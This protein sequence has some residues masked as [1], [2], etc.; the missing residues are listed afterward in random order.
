MSLCSP[1]AAPLQPGRGY[2]LPP[3]AYYR[4]DWFL[5]EQRQLFGRT[6]NFVGET[7]DLRAPGDFLTADVGGG[8]IVV[9]RDDD[10]MLRA[11]HNV[12]RHRGAKLLDARGN[13]SAIVC[14]YHRW[15]YGLDGSL[16]NVPQQATQLP[17]LDRDAWGLLPVALAE[18]KGLLFVNPDGGAPAFEDWLAGMPEIIGAFEPERLQVLTEGVY[19]FNANWKFYIEN[20]VDWYHLWYT[21]PRTLRMW[22]HHE[23]RMIQSGAHWASFEPARPEQPAMTPALKSIEGLTERQREN[24]AHLLFPN[25]T[26]F[27][28]DGYFATGLVTPLGPDRARMHFRALAAADQTLTPELAQAVLQAFREITE[29][30]DAGMTQRLQASVQSAAFA[31][32]PMTLEHEA[33][34]THFHDAYLDVL[35]A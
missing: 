5:R 35:D 31:V 6:W 33:P 23:G 13:C 1:S 8:P 24:G 7:R 34:I 4:Q 25:L 9:V 18:W 3:E 11:F 19:E 26:L 28:G 17:A 16:D 20:H 14:P 10:G 21:H 27:T 15:R 12:C 32:G 30:E 2:R 22:N 29:I